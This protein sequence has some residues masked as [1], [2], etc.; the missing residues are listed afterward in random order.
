[1]KYKDVGFIFWGEKIFM[2]FFRYIDKFYGLSWVIRCFI[3][4]CY[5]SFCM[6]GV[7]GIF[8][9]RDV[10]WNFIVLF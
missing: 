10:K 1:M 7:L 9:I 8:F 6:F 5:G 4:F 3:L 2:L